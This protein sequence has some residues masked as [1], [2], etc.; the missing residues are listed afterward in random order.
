LKIHLGNLSKEMTDAQV[1]ELVTPF[2]TPKTFELAKERNGRD[3][4]GF[5]FIEYETAE[6]ANAAI[7]ALNGKEVSGQ[8]LK[9]SEAR[10][11]KT[12]AAQA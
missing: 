8:V 10:P 2:G 9:A 1:N 12:A 4:R 7:A 6:E 11:R 5:A 3:S